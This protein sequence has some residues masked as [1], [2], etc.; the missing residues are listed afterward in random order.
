MSKSMKANYGGSV[1]AVSNGEAYCN[2]DAG[3]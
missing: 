1:A 2:K 3:A